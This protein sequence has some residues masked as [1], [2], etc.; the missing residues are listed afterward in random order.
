VPLTLLIEAPILQLERL[1][2][3]PPKSRREVKGKEFD[4]LFVT[5]EQSIR[6]SKEIDDKINQTVEKSD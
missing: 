2:L 6:I 5:N 4:S 3:F 1:V